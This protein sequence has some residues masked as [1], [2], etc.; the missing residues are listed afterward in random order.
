M[1]AMKRS[2]F[3]IAL[4][5]A[6][7]AA[8]IT[9]GTLCVYGLTAPAARL[10]EA[11][12]A[13]SA[14]V[15][16]KVC[17]PT[18]KYYAAPNLGGN[19]LGSLTA[20]SVVSA[21]RENDETYRVY[22]ENGETLGYCS[23]SGLVFESTKLI[24][25]V[26]ASARYV[27]YV[28]EKVIYPEPEPEPEPGPGVIPGGEGEEG[29][30]GGNGEG[31]APDTGAPATETDAPATDDGAAA[32]EPVI[33]YEEVTVLKHSEL[34]DVNE[35]AFSSPDVFAASS[36]T[37]LAQRDLLEALLANSSGL[38]KPGLRLCVEAAYS[39]S[40]PGELSGE[41]LPASLKTGAVAKITCRNN[42]GSV[43]KVSSNQY[44]RNALSSAGLI[45]L[46][47]TDWY[48]LPDC[49]GYLELDLNL[50]GLVYMIFE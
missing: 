6:V 38:S 3:T 9:L 30:E 29:G 21:S 23:V 11:G 43:V 4:I 20:G 7:C 10:G 18:L 2:K 36:E 33:I 1:K 24:A 5:C 48:Y 8:C 17:V 39:A 49:D 44:S 42:A 25:R 14:P 50:S 34:A 35:Y 28:I 19:S 45:R 37:V 46:G 32:P 47:N 31:E 22:D 27:T 13:A 12:D 15:P 26:P 16:M 40:V 41:E